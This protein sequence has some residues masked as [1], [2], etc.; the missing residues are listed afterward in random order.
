MPYAKCQQ[1]HANS[2]TPV[3][4]ANNVCAGGEKGI[5][6]YFMIITVILVLI[7]MSTHHKT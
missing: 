1:A 4:K 5:M 6:N 7:S 3:L 2:G